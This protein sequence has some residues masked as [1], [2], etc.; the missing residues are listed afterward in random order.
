MSRIATGSYDA[1]I[2]RI[3]AFEFLPVS[4][5][6]FDTYLQEELDSLEGAI[7]EANADKSNRRIVKILESAKKRLTKKI[8]DRAKREK[9]GQGHY[10]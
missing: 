3:R 1:V 4:D 6:L 2:V 7:R 10:L 9:K 5:E 8:E